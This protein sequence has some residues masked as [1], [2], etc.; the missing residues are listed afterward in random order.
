MSALEVITQYRQLIQTVCVYYGKSVF[1]TLTYIH[2]AVP[3]AKI[4]FF[5]RNASS[6]WNMS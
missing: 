2:A 5:S 3:Q 4:M 6:L 1:L